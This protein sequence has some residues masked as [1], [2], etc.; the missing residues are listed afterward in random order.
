MK[1]LLIGC[2][3]AMSLA[4]SSCSR[5]YP[6]GSPTLEPTIVESE[7]RYRK[8]YVIGP[9]DH[10]EVVVRGLPE[11]SRR[12]S[13][14]VPGIMVRPDGIITLPLI[15]D[16]K[17]AGLTFPQLKA[18]LT[19]RF[20]ERLADPEVTVIG[21][22]LREP[23]VY[24]LGEVASP[25]PV[26]LRRAWTAAQAI[27]YAGGFKHTGRRTTVALIRLTDQGHL[28]AHKIPVKARGQPSSLV[29]LQMTALEPDDI[30]FVPETYIAQFDQW[31]SQYINQPLQGVNSLLTP[32]AT[33]MLIEELGKDD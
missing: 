1:A 24:V 29:A 31:I 15:D 5:P 17:A 14:G 12:A 28:Q 4:L 2:A 16:L 18:E 13:E 26:P 22:G 6:S 19:K 20:S 32:V 10:L 23:M 7:V 27:A 9:G 33:F 11:V 21:I 25:Q 30:V 3:L 8:E